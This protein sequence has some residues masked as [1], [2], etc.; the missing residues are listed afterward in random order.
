MTTRGKCGDS[1]APWPGVVVGVWCAERHMVHAACALTDHPLGGRRESVKA[2]GPRNI[3]RGKSF[4]I[5]RDVGRSSARF[6]SVLVLAMACALAPARVLPIV[7]SY[8]A[9]TTSAFTAPDLASGTIGV[10]AGAPQIPARIR[11]PRTSSPS[12]CFQPAIGPPTLALYAAR[13]SG[14]LATRLG[15]RTSSASIP[16]LF[17]RGPP[18]AISRF[19]S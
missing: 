11:Q 12:G 4:V 18:T 15:A 6:V 7:S 9:R 5:L 16:S 13:R 17:V 1:V 19:A 14:V 3:Y 10:E 2:R 8:S